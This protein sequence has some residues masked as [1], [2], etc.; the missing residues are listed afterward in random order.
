MFKT[1]NDYTVSMILQLIKALS[2]NEEI[3]VILIRII[4]NHLSLLIYE[5]KVNLSSEHRQMALTWIM[6]IR[7]TMLAE[8]IKTFG[9]SD[10][11][12]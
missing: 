6:F 10:T 12:D 1:D 5:K 7:A 9:L 2:L 3:P 4:N 8:F 11:V